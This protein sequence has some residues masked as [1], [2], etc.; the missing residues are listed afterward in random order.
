MSYLLKYF[1]FYF[2][3]IFSQSI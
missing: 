1:S 3:N 2:Y